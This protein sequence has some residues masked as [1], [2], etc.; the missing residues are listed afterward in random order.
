M[1]IYPFLIPST[2]LTLPYKWVYQTTF[3]NAKVSVN[4]IIFANS[5]SIT[6]FTTLLRS[7]SRPCFLWTQQKMLRLLKRNLL[8]WMPDSWQTS[9]SR[10][11]RN[12]VVRS[13]T[14]K[15][16]T[17]LNKSRCRIYKTNGRIYRT[18]GKI[19]KTNGKIYKTNGR[20]Y[21][22]NGRIY[23]TNGRIY[24]ARYIRPTERNI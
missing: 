10:N 1:P 22:T 21:K 19:Y 8:I 14:M 4:G 16:G 13:I 5:A 3:V 6:A 2:S 18:K 23:K 12:V 9:F 11:G 20:I 7:F 24:R 17:K 15:R